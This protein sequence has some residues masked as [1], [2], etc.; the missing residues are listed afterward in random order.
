MGR[1][2]FNKL[3]FSIS[4]AP[5]LYQRQMTEILT[6]L[7]TVVCQMDDILIFGKNQTEHDQHLEAVLQRIQDANGMLNPP[8]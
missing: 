2:C 8:T 4:S 5:E 1:Y 7:P 6:G 3:P